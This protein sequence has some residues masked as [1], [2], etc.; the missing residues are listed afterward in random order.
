MLVLDNKQEILEMEKKYIAQQT[1]SPT[2]IKLGKGLRN[3]IPKVLTSESDDSEDIRDEDTREKKINLKEAKKLEDLKTAKLINKKLRFNSSLP[4]RF[5][6]RKKQRTTSPEK[7][8][9]LQSTSNVEVVAQGAALKCHECEKKEKEI[10]RQQRV[11][12]KLRKERDE[13]IELSRWL[14]EVKDVANFLKQ[15]SSSAVTEKPIAENKRIS[16][17][18]DTFIIP[19]AIDDAEGSMSSEGVFEPLIFRN[20][21][22]DEKHKEEHDGQEANV[23]TQLKYKRSDDGVTKLVDSYNVYVHRAVKQRILSYSRTHTQLARNAMEGV[24]K[25]EAL[26]TCSLLGKRSGGDRQGLDMTG[27]AAVLEFAE[28]YAKEGNLKVEHHSYVKKQLCTRL[29]EIRKAGKATP[30]QN[31]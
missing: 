7:S 21:H 14:K 16:K 24:F 2:E 30:R 6:P 28:H 17:D 8:E 20:E 3:K 19:E 27:F 13:A 23:S 9:G 12:K 1:L 5:S 26:K 18:E 4:A 11:I 10:D 15:R 31:V 25:E 22:A 29:C